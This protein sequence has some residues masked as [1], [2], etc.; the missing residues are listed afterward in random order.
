M[1][2]FLPFILLPL[3]GCMDPA[4]IM[5]P[6]PTV[7]PPAPRQA[8]AGARAQAGQPRPGR[9]VNYNGR[10]DGSLLRATLT[11]LPD[12]RTRAV[13]STQATGGRFCA[14]SFEGTGRF[15]GD[16][17]VIE[18]RDAPGCRVFLTRQGRRLEIGAGGAE[19]LPLHGMACG[20][21]GS[22]TQR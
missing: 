8:E 13:G 7:A 4:A 10:G 19:C 18:P 9:V 22:L 6:A 21:S 14:G 2:R 5:P 3:A 1:R 17:M 16:T 11:E 20:L 15:Q 12:G